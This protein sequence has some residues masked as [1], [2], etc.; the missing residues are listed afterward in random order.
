VE[1][2]DETGRPVDGAAV[3]FRMPEEG[4]GATF[5]HG[6][7]TEIRTTTP[8]GLAS[9]RS[10]QT[11]GLKG[12]YQVRVTAVKNQIRAGTVVSQYVSESAGPRPSAA[13]GSGG[14]RKWLAIAA[15]AGGAAAGAFA[16][17]RGRGGPG[18]ASPSAPVPTTPPQIGTPSITVGGPR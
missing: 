11:G 9:I 15:I 10:F 17:M 3:S 18:S 4:P 12:P 14:K 1:I 5:E 7:R 2:T 8:D 16:G 13:T 6:M